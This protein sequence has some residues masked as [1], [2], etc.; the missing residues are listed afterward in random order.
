MSSSPEYSSRAGV[1]ESTDVVGAADSGRLLKRDTLDL[2]HAVVI[3]VAVM[4]PAASVFFNANPS[5]RLQPHSWSG[6]RAA[7]WLRL[8]CR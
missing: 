1:A 6:T 3:S 8:G 2:R 4:S 7:S 5:Q